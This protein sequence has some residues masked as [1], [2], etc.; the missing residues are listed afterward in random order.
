M[1]VE[2][3]LAPYEGLRVPPDD[4]SGGDIARSFMVTGLSEAYVHSS[5]VWWQE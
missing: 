3:L 5:T 1:F 2:Q 4:Q